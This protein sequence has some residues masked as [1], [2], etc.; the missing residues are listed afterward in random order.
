M[1]KIV[2]VKLD[3]DSVVCASRRVLH[4]FDFFE[5]IEEDEVRL[6]NV[7]SDTFNDL[8]EFAREIVAIELSTNSELKIPFGPFIKE[9]VGKRHL[10]A[11][12]P[13]IASDLAMRLRAL[14]PEKLSRLTRAAE[15]LGF[16]KFVE[17]VILHETMEILHMPPVLINARNFERIHQ[18]NKEKE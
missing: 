18:L 9:R 15:F 12:L 14:S 1:E 6:P 2:K 4:H 10:A 7:S 16:R 3:D 13:S 5:E 11:H 17:L 8:M